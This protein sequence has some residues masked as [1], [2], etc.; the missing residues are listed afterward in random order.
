MEGFFKNLNFKIGA[1]II[2]V[3]IIFLTIMG[4]FF[5]GQFSGQGDRLFTY[6]SIFAVLATLLGI[7]LFDVMILTRVR[8]LVTVLKQVESGDLTARVGGSIFADEVGEL[9]RGVDAMVARLAEMVGALEKRMLERSQALELTTEV[10]RYLSTILN[11][12]QLIAQ[13]VEQVRSAFNYYYVQIYLLDETR[14]NL[15]LAGGTGEMGQI[16]LERRHSIPYGRGLVGRVAETKKQILAPDIFRSLSVEVVTQNNVTEIY[17]RETDHHFEDQW[18][19]EWLAKFFSDINITKQIA[20]QQFSVGRMLHLRYILHRDDDFAEIAWRGIVT[21]TRELN[22]EPDIRVL[23]KSGNIPSFEDLAPLGTD[24]LVIVPADQRWPATLRRLLAAHIPVIAAHTASPVEDIATIAPDNFQSGIVLARELTKL[25]LAKGQTQGKIILGPGLADRRQGF[26]YGL[27]HT[28]YTVTQIDETVEKNAPAEPLYWRQALEEQPDIIAAVGLTSL[29]IPA[30]AA[31][32]RESDAAWLIAGYDLNIETLKAIRE[33]VA[34]VAIGEHPYLQGYLPILALVEH[35]YRAKPLEDWQVEGWLPNP[36]L[37]ETRAEMVAP[38]VMGE[39]VI[40]V[41]EVQ[42]NVSG[43]LKQEDVNLLQSIADQV[44]IGLQNVRLF[45]EAQAAL[46]ESHAAHERYLEQAWQKVKAMAQGGQYHYAHP[47]A[48]ALDEVT[49]AAAKQEALAQN[50][51]TTVS[52]IDNNETGEAQS[53]PAPSLVTPITLRDK[54]IG[55]LQLHPASSDQQWSEDDLAIVEA[56]RD[57]LAQS[58]ENLRLFDETR[59]R[60]SRE[61]TIRQITDKLRQAPTLEELAKTASEELSK[62]LGV[63][64]SL[65]RVGMKETQPLTKNET[66]QSNK[67]RDSKI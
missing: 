39:Q 35:L 22:V 23:T 58:A 44:A 18:Y 48:P 26:L 10:S 55:V 49:M 30:L 12:E 46:A 17:R 52:L 1:L 9:Q 51:L 13:V 33:G 25:F 8:G 2:V 63:S 43:S 59:Q 61:Q 56:V 60:A 19:A 14:Q 47:D 57:Q 24:G 20:E 66:T 16:L 7:V 50:R 4:H 62:A 5:A 29:D 34:Q 38:I 64:H 3:E 40:G 67:N 65:V 31:L 28:D 41:L 42:H 54:A 32:K 45:A 6:F 37:P 21:A 27:R 15:V 36:L 11:Q 53:Q